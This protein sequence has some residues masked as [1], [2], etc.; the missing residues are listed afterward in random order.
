M[1]AIVITGAHGY[2]GTALARFLAAQGRA[3]RL[4]SRPSATPPQ[5]PAGDHVT[6]IEADLGDAAAWAKLMRGASAIVH[7]SARTDL[8]AAEA[9]PEEDEILNVRP[10]RAL[11]EAAARAEAPPKIVFAST[12]TVFGPSPTAPAN[13]QTP[14]NP[15]SVYDRHKAVC[16]ALLRDA[17]AAG[18]V[19]ACSLRL[20]NVYGLRGASVN[21]NRGILNVMMRRALAGE[22]LTTYG[23]GNYTRDFI[24]LDDVVRAF[25]LA[26]DAGAD[27]CDGSRYVIATG[28]GHAVA[29]AYGL[30]AD[31]AR[32]ATGRRPAILRVAEPADLHPIERRNFV[33]DSSLFRRRTG[34]R[35]TL[36]LPDGIAR[37]FAAERASSAASRKG[38]A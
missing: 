17:T 2:I 1:T 38:V 6:R 23:D 24:H 36:S 12:V 20:S 15:C 19:Q 27:V 26:A 8:R 22:A 21:A 28:Q 11:L 34:W 10:V 31:A 14:D 25:A 33:G 32:D 16:E 3:L 29:E 37:F 13:E 18:L 30:I 35:P 5:A 7:L 9:N 4:V